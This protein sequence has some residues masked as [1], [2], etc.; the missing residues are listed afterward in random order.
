MTYYSQPFVRIGQVN[1]LYLKSKE[2]NNGN[3]SYDLLK[4]IH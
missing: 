1:H 3:L 2:Q 4:Q